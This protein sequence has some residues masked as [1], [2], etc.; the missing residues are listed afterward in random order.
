M[1]HRKAFFP[2]KKFSMV[3]VEH[4]YLSSGWMVAISR[5]IIKAGLMH[6]FDVPK[7]KV[8]CMVI[9]ILLCNNLDL[10]IVH[11]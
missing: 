3:G 4:Y 11:M 9:V 5:S 6:A 1:V 2:F 8:L 10:C 7:G